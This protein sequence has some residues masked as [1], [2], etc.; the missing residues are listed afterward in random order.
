MGLHEPK[1]G[2]MRGAT[3]IGDRKQWGLGVGESA[4]VAVCP[5]RFGL[6]FPWR[7]PVRRLA[8]PHRGRRGPSRVPTSPV[9]TFVVVASCLK[10]RVASE[11]CSQHLNWL[12][13]LPVGHIGAGSH[14][15]RLCGPARSPVASHRRRFARG[16]APGMHQLASTTATTGE[17]TSSPAKRPCVVPSRTA[18]TSFSRGAKETFLRGHIVFFSEGYMRMKGRCDFRRRRVSRGQRRC[19]RRPRRAVASHYSPSGRPPD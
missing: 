7:R 6:L 14:Q 17:H 4:I 9:A 5:L 18:S 8:A 15:R 1:G 16:M 19:S 3:V 10:A 12:V 2:V 11:R 13:L